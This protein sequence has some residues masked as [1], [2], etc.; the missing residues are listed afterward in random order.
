MRCAVC[1][2]NAARIPINKAR[3]FLP[4]LFDLAQPAFPCN[5][6]MFRHFVVV[7]FSFA[8]SE[9]GEWR[10]RSTVQV[11]VAFSGGE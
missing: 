7:A 5:V 4:N 6:A 1:K 3:D 8:S 10:S 9:D 2:S 11:R